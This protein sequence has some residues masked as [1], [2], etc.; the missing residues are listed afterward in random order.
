MALGKADLIDIYRKR[1]SRYDRS[2]RLYRLIGFGEWT[3]R[4][5]AVRHLGLRPGD[6]VVEIGCGTG[7]N[8]PLLQDAV[9]DAGRVVG[10]DMTD[11]MLAEA[12]ER[13]VSEGWSNV[14]LIRS[15]A[16]AYAFPDAVDGILSTF[17]LTLIPEYDSVIHAGSRAL[18]E[19]GRWV[20]ADL[21][22]PAGGSQLV[23]L[24]LLLPLFRPFGVTL[25]LERRRPWESLR[26]HLTRSGM[27]EHYFGFVYVAWAEK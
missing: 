23:L 22:L 14:E 20:V 5:R 9:G 11:A 1:A 21:K 8:F 6:T 26:R 2:T 18:R 15:D 25:D 24:P 10:V 4:Q 27:E 12:R 3:Y 13:V 17:A 16:A 7:L 19:G